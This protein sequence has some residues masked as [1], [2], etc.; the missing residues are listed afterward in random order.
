MISKQE[1]QKAV[2]LFKR[3]D[4]EGVWEKPSQAFISHTDIKAKDSLNTAL[5]LKN[6]MEDKI[7]CEKVLNAQFNASLWIINASYYSM[8]FLAQ[9]LLS[10]D[11][12][13]LPKGTKDTHK[14]LVLAVLYYYLIKGSG[15]EGKNIDWKDIKETRMSKAFVR[16][17]QSQN[18]AEELLQI[19]RAKGAVDTLKSELDKRNQ[20]TYQT[21]ADIELKYAKTSVRRAREFRTTVLEYME[22]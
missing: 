9:V 12:K 11:G 3:W 8:F 1:I 19:N 10:R 20:F 22:K 14:T 21:T 16:L 4:R 13:K 17:R 15:L 5:A 18:D 7:L 2:T 6:L